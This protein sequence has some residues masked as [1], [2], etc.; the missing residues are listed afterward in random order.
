MAEIRKTFINFSQ[1][2]LNNKNKAE[3]KKGETEKIKKKKVEYT[4]QA[5]GEEG[6][7]SYVTKAAGEEGSNLSTKALNEE[8]GLGGNFDV[9]SKIIAEEGGDV[10][11]TMALGE[12]G[13]GNL[14]YKA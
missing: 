5:L 1:D 3:L 13:G 6:G 7:N 9:P 8:G 2:A 11:T 10:K 12:E 4:T 14:N